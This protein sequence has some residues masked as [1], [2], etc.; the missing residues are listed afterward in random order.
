MELLSARRTYPNARVLYTVEVA[1]WGDF[2]GGLLADNERR[3]L[4]QEYAQSLRRAGHKAWFHHNERKK[5]STVT[6]GIFDHSAIDS[7]SGIHSDAVER[8]MSQFS[9]RLVN[10]ELLMEPLIPR[11]Q[12][13]EQESRSLG[14]LKFPALA[15]L[16]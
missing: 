16:H 8:V 9:A 14:W 12:V 5:M 7:D 10:G 15:V 1:V 11:I 6:V 4:A 13:L 3:R 2:G